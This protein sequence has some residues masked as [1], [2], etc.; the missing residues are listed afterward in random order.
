M[1]NGVNGHHTN[2]H[3]HTHSISFLYVSNIGF[4]KF[5]FRKSNDNIIFVVYFDIIEEVCETGQILI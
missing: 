4:L 3:E 5:Y 1:E 2:M